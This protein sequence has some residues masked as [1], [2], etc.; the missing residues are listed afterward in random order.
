MVLPIA[1]STALRA[2]TEKK[3]TVKIFILNILAGAYGT[4]GTNNIIRI[5]TTVLW[6]ELTQMTI[7]TYFYYKE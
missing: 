4:V 7:A 5:P 6:S 3:G 2:I 1:R